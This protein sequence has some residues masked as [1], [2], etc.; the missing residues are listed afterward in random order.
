MDWSA[1]PASC[2]SSR[3]LR[4]QVGTSTSRSATTQPHCADA[5]ID[6]VGTRHSR[7]ECHANIRHRL[8]RR[9]PP[10]ALYLDAPTD[11]RPAGASS[12]WRRLHVEA[13]LHDVT[14]GGVVVL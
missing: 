4:W 10:P 5:Q 3:S 1:L 13:E 6:R 9:D 12:F 11:S 7:Y 8:M 14:V 2:S